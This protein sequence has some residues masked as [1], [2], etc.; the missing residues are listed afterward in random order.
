[1]QIS[2]HN[3]LSAAAYRATV[4]I[5][6]PPIE[7]RLAV[8]ISEEATWS[9]L[10]RRDGEFPLNPE[11][12]G[13]DLRRQHG[14]VVGFDM[15][16]D[17]L[18][19]NCTRTDFGKAH[20][21]G[22]WIAFDR[23]RVDRDLLVIDQMDEATA[24]G[25]EAPAEITAEIENLRA[26]RDAREAQREADEEAAFQA[27]SDAENTRLDDLFF[28]ARRIAREYPEWIR[29]G[30]GGTVDPHVEHIINNDAY[31]VTSR[32]NLIRTDLVPPGADAF[33]DVVVGCIENAIHEKEHNKMLTAV[34]LG[35][36]ALEAA[37]SR[38]LKSFKDFDRA[39]KTGIPDPTNPDNVRVFLK[40]QEIELRWN[41]WRQRQEIRETSR[42][43]GAATRQGDWEPLT[44]AVIGR[45]MTLAGDTQYQ[46]R[47]AEA[48]FRRTVATI[49]RESSFDPLLERLATLET[50]WDG[51]A[52]LSGWLAR[53][54][55]VTDD[56]YH[57]AVSRNVVGGLVRRAR[58]PGCKHDEVM[59]LSSA[60]QGM[61]K[62]T[63]CRILALDDEWFTD[64]VV[65]DGSPQNVIP[66]LHGKWCIELSELG[67]MGRRDAEHV[68]RFLST[69]ADNF[70]AKYQAIATDNARRCVF[71]GTTNAA[72]AL[73]DETGGRRW[74]PVNVPGEI[75]LEWLRANIGQIVGEAAAL[76]TR[77]ES[78][79]IPREVWNAAAK[80]QE[81]ARAVS[82]VEELCHEWFDRPT[83]AGAGLWIKSTDIG[84][85]LKL[86]GQSV[87][88][89]YGNFLKKLGYRDES[90]VVPEIGKRTR[91]WVR[92]DGKGIDG[93][94]QLVPSQRQIGSPVEM[95]M[96]SRIAPPMPVTIAVKAQ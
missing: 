86:S 58:E 12:L 5:D 85:A 69:Q 94:I 59:L 11:R 42:W 45:L 80:R 48:L 81:A 57:A 17:I 35:R 10:D 93:C 74:L 56:A 43:N 54:A 50:G 32:G 65:F 55:G 29:N 26:V 63:L 38:N 49:A 9:L 30:F 79:A 67:N 95:Q 8:R 47:P 72:F 25:W 16:L 64:S 14:D 82:P 68:K 88:A 15:F 7:A 3:P 40:M 71:I 34:N 76:H 46:F 33:V 77:G 36:L 18:E 37:V 53:A 21:E 83:V 62:S 73:S 1:M 92:S 28:E 90:I 60:A 27:E 4:D 13:W 84:Y 78:F 52:R 2:T 20:W 61:G 22:V 66:Q 6:E 19:T 24:F 87:N 23:P 31:A 75:D 96:R 51:V 44:D 41:A 91:L 89:K 39:A 70:T